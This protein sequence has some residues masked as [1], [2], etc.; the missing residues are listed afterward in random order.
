[1]VRFSNI[2]I[3]RLEDGILADNPHLSF[4]SCKKRGNRLMIELVL[5][6]DKRGTLD[7]NVYSLT[8]D[9]DGIIESV[10]V[11][12]GTALLAVGDTVKKGDIIVDGYAVVKEQTV[13]I[14]VLAYCTV[15]VS[16]VFHYKTDKSGAEEVAV[17]LA[18]SE[19]NDKEI[20]SYSVEVYPDGDGYDYAVTTEYRHVL[21]AG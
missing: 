1:M 17:M 7:D 12:R 4:A 11:Y 20:I 5:S 19:L 2:D 9:V 13:K 18:L 8:S 16:T 6:E 10:K 3:E 15:K 14:N 21:R